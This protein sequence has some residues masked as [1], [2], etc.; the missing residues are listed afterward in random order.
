MFKCFVTL[1]FTFI[2]KIH[3]AG[4]IIEELARVEEDKP[5]NRFND[6]KCDSNGRLWAGTM[7]TES[8][9]GVLSPNEGNFYRFTAGMHTHYN[10]NTSHQCSSTYVPMPLILCNTCFLLL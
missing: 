10:I 2:V 3:F 7:A 1:H 4:S 9:P 5:L 6:A 8:A